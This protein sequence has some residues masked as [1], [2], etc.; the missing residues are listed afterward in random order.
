MLEQI[1]TSL[2]HGL[3]QSLG[4]A[5]L[6]AFAWGVVSIIFSPCHLASVP[7][8]VGFS[9]GAWSS[10]LVQR[11]NRRLEDA[12]RERILEEVLNR[13]PGTRAEFLALV[14]DFRPKWIALGDFLEAVLHSAGKPGGL[15]AMAW[16]AIEDVKPSATST[17]HVVRA[18]FEAERAR[19]RAAERGAACTSCPLHCRPRTKGHA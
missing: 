13:K 6:A 5:L 18:L 1:L 16:A 4:W 9:V 8:V 7:L 15:P 17:A 14:E 3:S 11:R 10:Y 19:E 12:S 2:S